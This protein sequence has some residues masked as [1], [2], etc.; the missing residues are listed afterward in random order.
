MPELHRE[1][2]RGTPRTLLDQTITPVARVAQLTWPGG[3]LEWHRPVAVEVTRGDRVQRIPIRNATRRLVAG[4]V[5]AELALGGF[6]WWA[7]QR[8]VSRRVTQ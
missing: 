1:D 7:Q 5:L 8:F 4:I 3:R 2:I 6:V